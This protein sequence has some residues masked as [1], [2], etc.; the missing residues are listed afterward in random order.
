AVDDGDPYRFDHYLLIL[1]TYVR[2]PRR[3]QR[4]AA[5]AAAAPP[6]PQQPPQPP[7]PP[8][9]LHYI[10]AEDEVF[11]R[12]ATASCTFPLYADGE[13]GPTPA[14]F[15]RGAMLLRRTVCLLPADAMPRALRGIHELL[16]AP[17]G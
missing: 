12:L 16:A 8:P 1:K 17:T 3:R 7:Q 15:G 10:N 5:A 2:P 14:A 9:Q 13:D 4:D 11:H 6:S